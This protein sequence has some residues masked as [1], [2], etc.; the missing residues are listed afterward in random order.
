MERYI[1][2][3]N[4]SSSLGNDR[5]GKAT[6]FYRYGGVFEG[7]FRD[8]ERNGEGLFTWPD[9]DQ[10]QGVWRDGSRFGKGFFIPLSG[11][12]P[13]EQHWTTLDETPHAN[14]STAV[15]RKWPTN[16]APNSFAN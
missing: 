13:M 14:Y 10:Y 7:M 4:C 3:I 9:Q 8:D 2:F 1:S 16:Y 5:C 6:Y 11:Q 12:K 15:P